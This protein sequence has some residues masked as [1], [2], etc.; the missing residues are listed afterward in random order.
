M[1][2]AAYANLT[3]RHETGMSLGMA[4]ALVGKKKTGSKCEIVYIFSYL[5]DED[6]QQT[7]TTN[8]YLKDAINPSTAK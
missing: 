2:Q 1:K 8:Q 5:A 6:R 7:F 3:W 4:S